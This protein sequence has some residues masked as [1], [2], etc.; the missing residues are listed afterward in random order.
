[1][2]K[3]YLGIAIGAERI[4]AVYG[5]AV[6]EE[7]AVRGTYSM[8]RT[9]AGMRRDCETFIE[10]FSLDGI[11][12]G[13]VFEF[14]PH[15]R[16]SRIPSSEKIRIREL[17]RWHGEEYL[18]WGTDLYYYD[19]LTRTSEDGDVRF[20][21]TV[22]LPKARIHEVSDGLTEAECAL[23]LI[24][25]W[26]API[27]ST[28]K[29]AGPFINGVRTEEG[30]VLLCAWF[31]AMCTDVLRVPPTSKDIALGIEE[32]RVRLLD[33]GIGELRGV[34]L[35]DV[36]VGCAGSSEGESFGNESGS[37]DADALRTAELAEDMESTE[38]A[39]GRPEFIEPVEG[40]FDGDDVLMRAA[41][42]L[43][44][45]GLG[46]DGHTRMQSMWSRL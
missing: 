7:G 21:F 39:F 37:G 25:Y 41:W 20:V 27:M 10:R 9:E 6:G 23:S 8:K 38:A 1:M 28:Y 40:M 35:R 29:G 34:D 19:Y 43:V 45:R 32:M 44:C 14:E 4:A 36:Y 22:S 5:S 33:M 2:K 3:E 13:A 17:L 12:A 26:P 16:C 46:T 11:P 24:D 42:G 30:D 31:K 15:V 18:P